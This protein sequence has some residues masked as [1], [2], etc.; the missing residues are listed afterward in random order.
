MRVSRP[1]RQTLAFFCCI[2][3]IPVV[4]TGCAMK[5]ET[6]PGGPVARCD[7]AVLTAQ[8][9][10][11]YYQ[12]AS[13][14][15]ER[16]FVVVSDSDPRLAHPDVRRKACTV[17]IGW[18]PGFWSTSGWVE[19]K[20]YAYGTHMHTSFMRRGMVWTGANQ[21]VL[22]AINDVASVRAAAGA[23]PADARDPVPVNAEGADAGRSTTSRLEELN[24]MRAQGLITEKEYAAKRKSILGEH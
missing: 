15:L 8:S 16:S 9:A 14:T 11:E 10:G 1:S 2:A 20:D 12:R 3:V 21:D 23:L 7:Y 4:G 19:V 24:S 18:S 6:G 22:D 17:S 13:A 5:R